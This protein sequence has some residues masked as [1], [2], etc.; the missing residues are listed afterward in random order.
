MATF[1]NNLT[2]PS[3]TTSSNT[4]NS[5][6]SDIKSTHN[7]GITVVNQMDIANICIATVGFLLNVFTVT[8][9][10]LYKP[11]HKSMTNILISNQ[12]IIDA[13]TCI[14]LFISTLYK[15]NPNSAKQGNV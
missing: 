8:I 7:L 4:T 2:M 10:Y 13:V 6:H 15:Y 14:F 9:I 1:N 11:M 3:N 5:S 12:S